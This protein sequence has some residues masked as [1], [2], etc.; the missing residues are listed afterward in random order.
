MDYG[1]KSVIEFFLTNTII[2]MNN[3]DTISFIKFV[4]TK[5]QIEELKNNLN[6][7]DEDNK[8]AIEILEK[9]LL[10]YV[11]KKDDSLFI[12]VDNMSEF[13]K[14]LKELLY[15]NTNSMG[16]LNNALLKSI[17][18]RMGVSDINAVNDFLRKQ[19]S[20]IKGNSV[21]DSLHKKIGE[22]KDCLFY[23]QDCRNDDFFETNRHIKFYVSKKLSE[24]EERKK[25]ENFD[26]ENRED[27]IFPV[28]HYAINCEDNKKVCYIYGIQ[29]LNRKQDES[30]KQV[31][32]DFKK[33]LRN[34][35]VSPD[36]IFTL[37]LFV[38][39]LKMYNIDT[40]VVPLLQVYNYPY[41]QEVSKVVK[42]RFNEYINDQVESKE[43]NDRKYNLLK[44]D[45]ER[46]VDK[47]D[48]ISKNR[49][50]R[51]LDIFMIMQEKYDN[52]EFLTDPF[53]QGDY[54]LI[55]IKEKKKENYKKL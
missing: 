24:E 21:F 12:K 2:G 44:L 33:K 38:K 11:N 46:F 51:L 23:V 43:D 30:V 3:H 55:K 42:K 1:Y 36:F 4:F 48:T 17:W 45:Y 18:L 26:F 27:Y 22:Y 39:L 28:V 13:F 37:N 35:K 10:E 20:F 31:L 50:E 8:L 9:N 19:I 53:I 47:E 14:L 6:L 54:L 16:I 15:Q 41:H 29:N 40:I 25:F 32:N 34:K 52:I 7:D 49:T 5:K